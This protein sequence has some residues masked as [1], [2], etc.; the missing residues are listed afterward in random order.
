MNEDLTTPTPVNS[1]AEKKH[2]FR[3]E[4]WETSRFLLVALAIVVPIRLFIAQ[5][6]IVSG[7]SMDPTFK[8]K[9]YLIVDEL[10][11]NIG[12]PARGDV[13]IFKYPKNQKQYFIKRVIGLPGETVLVDG[14]GKVFIK[15]E[16]GEIVLT[17]NEPYV[18]YPK[19]DSVER[20][21][22]PGEYFM[23]G[24]NRAGSF[25]SRA[26]GPVD[27]NLIVGKAFLRLFPFTT[28][29]VLPGQFRQ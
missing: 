1:T 20:T 19:D 15:D 5:P 18:A 23:M 22:N 26:W 9:Q 25:D 4:A 2:S 14:Q 12:D 17:M 3:E 13:V 8:D 16:N 27:R 28:I 10:S 21:L 11:Y 24:D 6:F 7:A 29:D